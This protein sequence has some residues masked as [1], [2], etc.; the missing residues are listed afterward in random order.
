MCWVHE[1]AFTYGETNKFYKDYNK[2]V[3]LDEYTGS[4]TGEPTTFLKDYVNNNKDKL[5]TIVYTFE[6]SDGSNYYFTG[7]KNNK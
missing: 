2:S 5:N 4:S 1:L 3:P 7:F 6:S